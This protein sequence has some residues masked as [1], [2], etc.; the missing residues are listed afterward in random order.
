MAA[1]YLAALH[2]TVAALQSQLSETQYQLQEAR[3]FGRLTRK[4]H[5]EDSTLP[6]DSAAAV[7]DWIYNGDM[8]MW[9]EPAVVD[10]EPT[11]EKGGGEQQAFQAVQ[12][13][14]E[15]V[16]ALAANWSAHLEGYTY[17]LHG[18][19]KGF[20]HTRN[21]T[22]STLVFSPASNL[23]RPLISTASVRT[24]IES[25]TRDSS[26]CSSRRGTAPSVSTSP[27]MGSSAALTR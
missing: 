3:R 27:I 7:R 22:E 26:A 12:T 6:Q 14:V 1:P 15:G 17:S 5:C 8:R 20:H 18:A 16:P 2:R 19:R 11:G 10:E 23:H 13:W 25:S 9:S 24:Q 4:L 21:Y